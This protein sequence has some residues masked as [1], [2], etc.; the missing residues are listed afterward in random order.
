ME[1]KKTYDRKGVGRRL[2]DRRIQK[3]WSRNYVAEKVDLTVKYYSDIERGTCGMSV[4]TLM[5]LTSL[6]GFSIDDLIYGN[7]LNS[8]DAEQN[9]LIQILKCLPSQ[10]QERCT[11]I[12][13][14]LVDGLC[15]GSEQEKEAQRQN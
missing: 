5:A 2:R 11:Q 13:Y 4:E 12:L 9:Q 6:Y 3:G 7:K 10:M 1:K 8:S 14:L 15:Y